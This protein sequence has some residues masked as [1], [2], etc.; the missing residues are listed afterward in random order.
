MIKEEYWGCIFTRLR[1]SDYA[2]PDEEGSER[3]MDFRFMLWLQILADSCQTF[4]IVNSGYRT[5]KHN[6]KVG[7]VP[8]SSHLRGLA[9]DIKADTS[10][11]KFMII[12]RALRLGCKRIGIYRNLVHVDL[13]ES[14]PQMVIW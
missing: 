4:F 10:H 13:D 9:A 6:M 3:Y 7:G 14:K 1:R 11:K 2:S 12:E 5:L 8:D